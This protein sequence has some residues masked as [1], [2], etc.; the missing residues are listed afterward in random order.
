MK[1]IVILI[2][3]YSD[4]EGGP[5]NNT[6]EV[7]DKMEIDSYDEQDLI[8]LHY[9][10]RTISNRSAAFVSTGVATLL[11][12][13]EF[14]PVSVGVDGTVYRRHPRYK[15]LMEE[16]LKCLVKPEIEVNKNE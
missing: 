3:L 12:K 13:M 2:F 10:A 5:Y 1:S 4:P 14:S 8:D 16:N 9:I 11:N 7:L 15:S 6:K